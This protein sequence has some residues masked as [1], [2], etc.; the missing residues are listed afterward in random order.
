MKNVIRISLLALLCISGSSHSLFGQEEMKEEKQ[1]KN[2]IRINITNPL[3]FGDRSLVLGYERVVSPHSSF[4]LNMGQSELPKFGLFDAEVDDPDVKLM[5]NSKGSGF[6]ST[7]DFRFYLKHENKYLAPHGLYIGPYAAYASMGRKNTWELN[8]NSFQGEVITDFNLSFLSLG[9]QMGYQ[10]ILFKRVALDVI[11]F[12][13]GLA[14]YKLEA[15]LDTT[16]DADSESELYQKISDALTERF[17]GY[18]FVID[19]VDFKKTGSSN[20][21]SFGYRYVVHLGFNF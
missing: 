2:V 11:L 12:G 5:K 4:S 18:S 3:I 16:L 10:F 15:K 1:R 7:A 8:T 6:N 19:D 13:P 21:T 20:V 17:P 9:V 14:F